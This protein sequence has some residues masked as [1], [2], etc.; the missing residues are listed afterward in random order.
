MGPIGPQRKS[1][2]RILDPES[3]WGA[4][5]VTYNFNIYEEYTSGDVNGAKNSQGRE[6]MHST[7]TN[8]LTFLSN[9]MKTS[10]IEE[11]YHLDL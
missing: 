3:T 11:D 2:V 9:F 4:A 10:I 8:R 7:L 1:S 6:Q 5:P